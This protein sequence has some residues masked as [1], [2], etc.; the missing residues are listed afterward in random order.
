MTFLQS[1]E[2]E[3]FQKSVG[4]KTWRICGILVI[5]HDLPAGFNYLYCPHP[6]L[7]TTGLLL[8]IA[9]IAKG[10]RSVFLKIDPAENFQLPIS[11][12]QLHESASV[13]PSKTVVLD[14]Q[15]SE[16]ELLRAMHEKMRYNI[17]FAERRGVE[18][19]NNKGQIVNG[20]EVFWELLQET[21][22]RDKFHTH[23]RIYF[24]KLI[25]VRSNNF[26]NELFFAKYQGMILAA[27]IV[28][29]YRGR[30]SIATYLHGASSGTH[31]GI[32]APHL[33]HWR[34]IQEA[35]KRNFRYYDF[36]GIDDTK[37]PGLT[38]FKLGF[39]GEIVE[40][41]TSTDIIYRRIWYSTYKLTKRLF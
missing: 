3:E 38:R 27:A 19:A 32:M 35:R 22:R 15:K 21:A 30:T 24:E 31:R 5:R 29:F 2:W 8:E 39:S 11:N 6:K 7:V 40:H 1:S 4:R 16:E 10:E 28:N 36:W 20:L 26:S 34:I 14:I 33:L 25:A 17:R 37:W 18:A 9:N 12:F 41:P 23:P 13:Q